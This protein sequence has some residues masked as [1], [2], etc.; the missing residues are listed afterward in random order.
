MLLLSQKDDGAVI[1]LGDFNTTDLDENYRR[2][3]TNYQDAFREVGWGLG[4]TNP[5]WSTE[6]A[7]EGLPF[8]SLYQR[9]DYVFYNRAFTALDARVW[10]SSGGSDHRP[11]YVVLAFKQ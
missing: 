7:R 5:D 3:T 10:P 4:F 9:I 6:Q 11:L 8:I 2:I 1:L